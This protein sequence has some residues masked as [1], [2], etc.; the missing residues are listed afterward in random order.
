MSLYVF[1]Y[2]LPEGVTM[3]TEPVLFHGPD[4]DFVYP[5]R[6]AVDVIGRTWPAA[7]PEECTNTEW[8]GEWIAGQVLVCT[9]CGLDCT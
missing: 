3:R 9:G 1:E 8:R 7:R 2:P 6:R 5:G 4:R